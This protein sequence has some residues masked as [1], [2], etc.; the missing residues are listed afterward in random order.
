MLI[1]LTQLEKDDLSIK[2]LYPENT[3]DLED[4]E[5]TL[6]SSCNVSLTLRRR[7]TDI[8][9]SG[10]IETEVNLLCDRCLTDIKIVIANKFNLICLPENNLNQTDELILERRELDFCFYQNDKL[11]LDDIVK[12]QIQLAIPMSN[13]CK[14]NCLGLC[15]Q[16]GQDLNQKKCDCSSKDIDPRWSALTDLKK[17][18][19]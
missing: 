11:N 2:H 6:A 13:L 7:K 3:L 16:C 14:E 15:S 5:H 18:F 1:D 9:L 4:K 8:D 12:E 10:K 19:K 17:K